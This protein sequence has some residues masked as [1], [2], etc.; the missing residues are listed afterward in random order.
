MGL[1]GAPLDLVVLPRKVLEP[2]GGLRDSMSATPRGNCRLTHTRT[3]IR[4]RGV[5]G[6]RGLRWSHSMP[7]Q[8]D[9]APHSGSAEAASDPSIGEAFE[10]RTL[11]LTVAFGRRFRFR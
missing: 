4:G 2:F 6:C 11:R 9:R 5:E 10:P 8:L 3:Q 7:T 1:D